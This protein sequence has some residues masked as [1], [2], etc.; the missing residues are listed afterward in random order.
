[1][2]AAAA[3]QQILAALTELHEPTNG[4]GGRRSHAVC[5]E[6]GWPYPCLSVRL[7]RGERVALAEHVASRA[8]PSER[9][10]AGAA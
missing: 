2:I 3:Q 4:G 7:A 8:R 5:R 6:C 9:R 10:S 1:M